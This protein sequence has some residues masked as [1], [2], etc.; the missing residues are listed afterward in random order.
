MKLHANAALSLKGRRELYRRVL[1]GGGSLSEAAGAAE[2]SVRCAR[3]C[4]SRYRAEGDAGLLDRSSA[5]R[6]IPHRTSD[7]RI[8]VIAACGQ[9]SMIWVASAGLA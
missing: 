3:K 4:V 5:P 6:L 8:Q 7:Q 2:I 9:R 1:E